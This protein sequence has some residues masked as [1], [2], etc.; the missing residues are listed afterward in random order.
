M[1]IM[2]V[3]FEKHGQLHY[4][5]S[6]EQHY[7]VGDYVLYPT[8]YG[9]EV[10][11][12]V[13]MMDAADAVDTKQSVGDL[14]TIPICDGLA[15]AEELARDSR[16]RAKAAAAL[17]TARELVA[18]HNLSM[19]VLAVDWIDH[20]PATELL[21]AI[22]FQADGRVDFSSLVSELARALQARIDL[23]QIGARDATRLCGGLGTCGRTLCC[24]TWIDSF[25]P[26]GLRLAH[27]QGIQSTPNLMSGVCTKLKCC[28]MFEQAQY[29]AF[30]K[31]APER[32][33]LVS[34]PNGTGKVIGLS[35]PAEAVVVR[36]YDGTVFTCP[37]ATVNRVP[38]IQRVTTPLVSH[39]TSAA[40]AAT[41]AA[42]AMF[43]RE[44]NSEQNYDEL[45]QQLPPPTDAKS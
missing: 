34:T 45:N 10:A 5:D 31:A 11:E 41:S 29:R 2:A 8:S 38:I 17:L 40:S 28:L 6:A 23:R 35:T 27:D 22:Y 20:D 32:G 21:A 19:K 1:A 39:V 3:T 44:S 16:N 25:E 12:V 18:C 42:T 13:W 33:A 15:T 30:I 37:L 14:T 9:S 36:H 7:N 24:C 4:L 26:I 43:K